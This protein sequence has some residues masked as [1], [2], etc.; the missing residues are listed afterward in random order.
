MTDAKIAPKGAAADNSMKANNYMVPIA[1]ML[2]LV[3]IIVT[4]MFYRGTLFDAPDFK[5]I[6]IVS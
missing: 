6:T 2:A 4:E 1:G 3:L 5:T